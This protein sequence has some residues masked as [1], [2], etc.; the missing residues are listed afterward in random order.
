M[1]KALGL[2][3]HCLA[4]KKQMLPVDYKYTGCYGTHSFSHSHS[5]DTFSFERKK[6]TRKISQ[7][8]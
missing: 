2:F 8:T 5:R 1:T 4:N 6:I 3:D 7:K